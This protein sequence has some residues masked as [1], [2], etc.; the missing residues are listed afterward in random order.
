MATQSLLKKSPPVQGKSN[1][2]TGV[3]P[4]L[5]TTAQLNA[6]AAPRRLGTMT[7][8]DLNRGATGSDLSMK[9]TLTGAPVTSGFA[10]T[11]ARPS[12]L[13]KTPPAA[14]VA[15]A[16]PRSA[17]PQAPAGPS[18]AAMKFLQDGV[19]PELS[20][21]PAAPVNSPTT[22]GAQQTE[23]AN[24]LT[25]DGN[26]QPSGTTAPVN[27]GQAMGFS[28]SGGSVPRGQDAAP[29]AVVPEQSTQQKLRS[30]MSSTMDNLRGKTAGGAGL[31]KRSF[32]N[33]K[34]AS[35]YSG[36]VKRLFGDTMPA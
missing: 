27:P 16:T 34:S 4:T 26:K 32:T 17:A 15:A 30:S 36:Y 19:A 11:T 13:K 25:G 14:P 24:P 28:R 10:Q 1:W 12:L 29:A 7:S 5:R 3:Q 2:G 22:T 9:P 33:P 23:S 8:A 6:P 18:A 21:L 31:Y 35:L 20:P